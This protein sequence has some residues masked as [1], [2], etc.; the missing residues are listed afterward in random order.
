MALS[1]A[2]IDDFVTATL[3]KFNRMTFVDISLDL[4]E[5][6][7]MSQFILNN[8]ISFDG[9][10]NVT[11]N[12]MVTTS[13]AA[14]N[15]ALYAEDNLD[16]GNVLTKAKV[17]WTF[18]QTFFAYDV[19]EPEFQ[20]SG[21]RIQ[22]LLKV[23]RL[24][25]LNSYAKLAEGNF[26]GMPTNLTDPAEKLKPNGV[27]Y[28]VV[29]ATTNAEGFN[30]GN[31]ALGA[32]GGLDAS[33]YPNWS[34]YNA[35]YLKVTKDDL[36]RKARRA[37][38]KT[39]FKAPNP[40]AQLDKPS[41]FGHFVP[42]AVIGLL[43]E[44]L[45]K[46]NDSLGND[47]ASKDGEVIFR[48]APVRWAPSLDSDADQPW[49]GLNFGVF[50]MV[51]KTGWFMVEGKPMAVPGNHNARAVWTDSASQFRTTNRRRQFV[52]NLAPGTN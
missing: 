39:G 49:Y 9:G 52:I 2:G 3:P 10:E 22:D 27:K 20:S 33:V 36:I 15:T 50:N 23:R 45:E 31:N 30:G 37:A 41:K 34:N 26:W 46:Q 6:I 44:Q 42:D 17:D 8:K 7:A 28:W 38:R 43:E 11:W 48:R 32:P 24:D 4:Q 40:F 19:R 16:V 35:Q 21:E 25:A 51:C 12:V 1:L 5:Y 13:D 18:Q 14:T 47:I 29:K